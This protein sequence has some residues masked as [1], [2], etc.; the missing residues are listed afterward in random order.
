MYT[1]KLGISKEKQ[2]GISKKKNIREENWFR[3]YFKKRNITL[4][5]QNVME[6]KTAILLKKST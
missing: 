2:L 6:F 5:A 1:K 3:E 4:K